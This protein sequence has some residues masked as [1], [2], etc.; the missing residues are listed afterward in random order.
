MLSTICCPWSLIYRLLSTFCYLVNRLLSTLWY[1][2]FVSCRLLSD[3]SLMYNLSTNPQPTMFY[4][5]EAIRKKHLSFGHC[6]KVALTPPP[7][8]LDIARYRVNPHSPPPFNVQKR[9]KI[10]EN[11]TTSKLLDS[12]WTP[13]CLV[14]R[15]ESILVPAG[16]LTAQFLQKT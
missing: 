15:L 1:L 8:I 14:I 3:Q 9:V 10:G 12:G 13:T 5:R 2:A 16:F 7:S 4:L 11:K 6:P